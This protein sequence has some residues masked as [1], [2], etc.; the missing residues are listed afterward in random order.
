LAKLAAKL[1][2]DIRDAP[3]ELGPE[4]LVLIECPYTA[5]S[6]EGAGSGADYWL[7]Q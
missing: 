2:Q 7:I 4:E 1:A 3:G 5:G 6:A